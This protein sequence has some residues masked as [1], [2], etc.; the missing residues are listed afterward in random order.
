MLCVVALSGCEAPEDALPLEERQVRV[1]ATTSMI[2]D[3]AR[4]IGGDR[5][6]VDALMGPGVDPHL[7]RPSEGDVTRLS[8]AD[9][10]LYNGLDLEGRMGEVLGRISGRGIEAVALAEQLSET[11]LLRSEEFAGSFDPHVWM[12]VSRWRE[13]A[14]ITAE[15][16]ALLDPMHAEYYRGRLAVYDDTLATLEEHVQQ[17]VA[18]IP[19]ER[20]F[21]ITAHDAFGYFGEAYGFDVWGLQGLSTMAEAGTA[22]V[23]NLSRFIADQRIPAIFFESS[24]SPRTIQ[25]V[26]AAVRARGFEVETGGTLYS[27]A[28]G[29]PGSGADTY[30]GMIRHNV[31]TITNGLLREIPQ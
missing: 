24:I 25:A 1:V 30:I 3:L 10:V 29:E 12:D 31:D 17:Q 2:G 11:R 22:D 15:R 26:S 13:V 21:L 4:V 7:Y 20:R 28:L 5:V 9:I 18:Q 23:Q 6:A 8:R 16:L 14:A 19:P 27:D